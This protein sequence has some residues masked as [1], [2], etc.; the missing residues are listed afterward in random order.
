MMY[1]VLECLESHI[2]IKG[3]IFISPKLKHTYMHMERCINQIH[4][5]KVNQLHCRF[6]VTKVLGC[7]SATHCKGSARSGHSCNTPLV[8][9]FCNEYS[10]KNFS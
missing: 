5:G 3:I 4:R 1:G 6:Q 9:A 10:N 8:Y 2:K 7:S